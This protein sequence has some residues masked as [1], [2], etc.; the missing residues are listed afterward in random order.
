MKSFSRPLESLGSPQHGHGHHEV[1]GDRDL[2]Q[3]LRLTGQFSKRNGHGDEHGDDDGHDNASAKDL[4]NLLN[5]AQK[6]DAKNK[7]SEQTDKLNEYIKKVTQDSTEKE[8]KDNRFT[9]DQAA[10][11]G[12]RNARVYRIATRSCGGVKKGMRSGWRAA[13]RI[14][15]REGGY[16]PLSQ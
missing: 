5:E 16:I 3:P 9:K 15:V 13:S 4:C 12:S 2:R 8:S 14:S 11:G 1:L 10:Q 7:N 6:A